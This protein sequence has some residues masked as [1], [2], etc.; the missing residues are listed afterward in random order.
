MRLL[1][2]IIYNYDEEDSIK[3]DKITIIDKKNLNHII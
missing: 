1:T 2:Y 3:I